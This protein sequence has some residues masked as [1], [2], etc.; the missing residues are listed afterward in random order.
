MIAHPDYGGTTSYINNRSYRDS[1]GTVD[2]THGSTANSIVVFDSA[3]T[4]DNCS[5]RDALR[6]KSCDIREAIIRAK[7]P[8]LSRAHFESIKTCV[9]PS[10]GAITRYLTPGYGARSKPWTGRNFK[11]IK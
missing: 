2:I 8:S 5:D 10:K 3:S 4:T 6:N 1:S 9:G 11:R 7:G